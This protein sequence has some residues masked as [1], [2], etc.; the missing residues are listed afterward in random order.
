MILVELDLNKNDLMPMNMLINFL[1]KFK[2]EG[3][4]NKSKLVRFEFSSGSNKNISP[5]HP[6]QNNVRNYSVLINP[7]DD[8]KNVRSVWKFN[9][10]ILNL[11]FRPKLQLQLP[12]KSKYYQDL[13]EENSHL[14][15]SFN[16]GRLKIFHYESKSIIY[17]YK[18]NYGNIINLEYS[19]DGRVLG[20]GTES[21]NVYVLDAESGNLI[22]CFEGHRNYVTSIHFEEVI[23][24]DDQVI[25]RQNS[26]NLLES[27]DYLNTIET[28][29]NYGS[30]PYVSNSIYNKCPT[31]K[32]VT[33]EEFL[34]FFIN[35]QEDNTAPLD[36]RTL[37]RTRTSA[38]LNIIGLEEE[39]RASTTYDV[40]TVGLDG[41][42]GVWRIE[43]FYE[44][45]HVNENNYTN[46]PYTREN[47]QVVKS[48]PPLFILIHPYENIKVFY[49]DMKKA[50]KC[51][52]NRM[53]MYGN[54]LAFLGKRNTNGSYCY[55]TFFHYM[56]K[57]EE[58]DKEIS[59][60][61]ISSNNQVNSEDNK[62]RTP[63]N[64]TTSNHMKTQSDVN[65]LKNQMSDMT[66]KEYETPTKEKRGGSITPVKK[67]HT[68]IKENYYGNSMNQAGNAKGKLINK[69][70]NYA[71]PDRR[72]RTES[73]K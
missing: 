17:E 5:N 45:G 24:E 60:N 69:N 52:V 25:E 34:N 15:I 65:S 42:L 47:S 55:L 63:F 39:M 22:Y 72:S 58:K 18:T 70:E 41:N 68:N 28:N 33:S 2:V 57:S 4:E 51:P 61:L 12:N 73:K 67:N 64:T 62:S 29:R 59:N 20:L 13:Y 53:L 71:T 40:F 27:G 43:H 7:I 21:D 14:S 48:D 1:T 19:S 44:E 6:T 37:R 32:E 36:I 30:N 3:K 8:S 10:K 9:E 54:T 16:N 11:K 26:I 38:N 35:N 46:L 23:N 49:T 56:S 50:S 66:V 31:N